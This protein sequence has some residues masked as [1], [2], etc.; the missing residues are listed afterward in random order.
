MCLWRPD[1]NLSC[2]SSGAVYL[3]FEG[4]PLTEIWAL[5]IGPGWLVNHSQASPSFCCSGIG[6]ASEH[7]YIRRFLKNWVLLIKLS[8]SCL[9]DKH[10]TYL[11]RLLLKQL[12][13]GGLLSGFLITGNHERM[14]NQLESAGHIAVLN[15][16]AERDKCWYSVCFLLFF[17]VHGQGHGNVPPSYSLHLPISTHSV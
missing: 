7:N 9:C 10:Y 4:E 3:D 8:F 11:P 15:Q 14:K 1:I 13:S 16:K 5:P 17:S 6:I 2:H 12:I